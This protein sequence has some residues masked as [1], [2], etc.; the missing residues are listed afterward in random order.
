AL[1]VDA[2][3]D[4]ARPVEPVLHV[5]LDA[6]TDRAAA[7]LDH[8]VPARGVTPVLVD[9]EPR[10]DALRLVLGLDAQPHR[11]A[12]RR[13]LDVAA[14]RLHRGSVL[15]QGPLAVDR[16]GHLL[17]AAAGA[18]LVALHAGG[19]VALVAAA[20]AGG[21]SEI[22]HRAAGAGGAVAARPGRLQGATGGGGRDGRQLG[23]LVARCATRRGH[24][25]QGNPSNHRRIG[26]HLTHSSIDTRPSA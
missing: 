24:E 23:L 12:P 9:D 3:L 5:V 17:E 20:L 19:D 8:V 26:H 1:V 7:E 16:D 21:T 22:V 18:E 13:Q 11:V 14:G 4:G 2:A 6:R 25:G 15:Y 10:V